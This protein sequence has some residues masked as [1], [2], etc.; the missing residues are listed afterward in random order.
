MNG[1]K[2]IVVCCA[3]YFDPIHPGHRSHF[4]AAKA[5][6]DKLV[7]ITHSDE[8]CIAKKGFC[9]QPL[10]ERIKA[11][12]DEPYVDEVVVAEEHGDND[13]TVA[14]TLRFLRPSFFA[15][16]GDRAPGNMPQSEIDACITIRAKII[17]NVGAPKHPGW[18]ST[19]I[20]KKALGLE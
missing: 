3:G 11:L 20:G 1:Y 7:V 18:S 19:E 9:Y 15:K 12:L 6:G 10:A 14:N 2:V 13:G 4:A 5:L 17:Y 8:R 16:G